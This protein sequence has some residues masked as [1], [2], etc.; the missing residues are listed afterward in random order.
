MI[1]AWWF[2]YI[3][4]SALW[5]V[6]L[7]FLLKEPSKEIVSVN[8]WGFIFGLMSIVFATLV[9]DGTLITLSAV[10]TGWFLPGVIRITFKK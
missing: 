9:K 1:L 6:D 10:V 2:L 8:M 5:I 4:A 3:V 7:G